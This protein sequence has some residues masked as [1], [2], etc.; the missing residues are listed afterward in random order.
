M[1]CYT[2]YKS[3]RCTCEAR[4]FLCTIGNGARGDVSS[5]SFVLSIAAV[6]DGGKRPSHLYIFHNPRFTPGHPSHGHGGGGPM[7]MTGTAPN[8]PDLMSAGSGPVSRP[9]SGPDP[10]SHP[11]SRMSPYHD[12]GHPQAYTEAQTHSQEQGPRSSPS[13]PKQPQPPQE[14]TYQRK[15][16]L[17]K[18][19]TDG[20]AVISASTLKHMN[21]SSRD[22]DRDRTIR[23]TRST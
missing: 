19:F 22:R 15:H 5:H 7:G 21:K 9:G 13:Q 17:N 12:H 10:H 4:A 16:I 1:A 11:R 23:Q 3:K 6:S 14:D 8:T 20:E 2:H 18:F